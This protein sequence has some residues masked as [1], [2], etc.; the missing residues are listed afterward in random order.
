MQNPISADCMEVGMTARIIGY[1][2][3]C[4]T[5]ASRLAELG[6]TTGTEIRLHRVAPLGDPMEFHVRGYRLALRKDEAVCLRLTSL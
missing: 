3:E 6:L 5:T 4:S 2:D 1:A